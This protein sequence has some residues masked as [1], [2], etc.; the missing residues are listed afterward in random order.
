MIIVTDNE[1]SGERLYLLGHI[2]AISSL[3]E[4]CKPCVGTGG[5]QRSLGIREAWIYFQNFQNMFKFTCLQLSY[6]IMEVMQL[7]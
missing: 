2:V 5:S 7:S 1:S 6:Y 3:L 4:T